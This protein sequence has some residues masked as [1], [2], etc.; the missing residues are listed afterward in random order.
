MV[1][2]ELYKQLQQYKTVMELNNGCEQSIGQCV[3]IPM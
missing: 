2:A 3:Y 1:I